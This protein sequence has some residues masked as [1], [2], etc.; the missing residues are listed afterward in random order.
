MPSQDLQTQPS[1]PKAAKP[2]KGMAMEGVIARWYT[3]IRKEDAELEPVVRQVRELKPPRAFV[4]TRL[5]K[6]R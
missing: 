4:T 1:A 6:R 3:H 2:Y 5:G